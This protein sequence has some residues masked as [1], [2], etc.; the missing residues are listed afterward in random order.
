MKSFRAIWVEKKLKKPYWVMYT[1][2]FVC[3][4]GVMLYSSSFVSGQSQVGVAPVNDKTGI[5]MLGYGSATAKADLAHVILT[6]NTVNSN[7]GPNGPTFEPV[8]EKGVAQV[9]ATLAANGIETDTID[10]SLYGRAGFSGPNGPGSILEFSYNEPAKLNDFLRTMQEALKESRGPAI[11]QAVAVY[12]VKDCQSLEA[13]AWAAALSDAKR[14]AEAAAALMEVKLDVL[15]GATE[16]ASNMIYGQTP[17]GCAALDAAQHV[18]D[19]TSALGNRLNTA[20]KVEIAI[21]VE[22]SYAI[23]R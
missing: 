9:V 21:N 3:A 20:D 5:T 14:R 8:D 18:T 7:Y 2:T 19:L 16:K 12:L 10:V 23:T 22:A 15:Q 11:Q 17:G 1:S 6:V 13:K 4:L